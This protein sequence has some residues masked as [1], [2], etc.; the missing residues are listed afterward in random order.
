V[1][2]PQGESPRAA[3]EASP[4]PP[5]G[6]EVEVKTLLD[7]ADAAYTRASDE[8]RRLGELLQQLRKTDMR[9]RWQVGGKERIV[10]VMEVPYDRFRDGQRLSPGVTTRDGR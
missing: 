9:Q 1:V 8:L 6:S 5:A 10:D 2:T 7:A 4:G 3:V